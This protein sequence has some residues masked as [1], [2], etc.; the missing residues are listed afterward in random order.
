MLHK[1][2]WTKA[3]GK[4]QAAQ[5][6]ITTN[7]L[8]QSVLRSGRAISV[9][10]M[11]TLFD[12]LF[13]LGYPGSETYPHGVFGTMKNNNVSAQNLR[14]AIHP[15]KHARPFYKI[16]LKAFARAGDWLS[17]KKLVTLLHIAKQAEIAREK[18]EAWEKK[19]RPTYLVRKRRWLLRW[20]PKGEDPKTWEGLTA[21]RIRRRINYLYYKSSADRREVFYS[22]DDL[23]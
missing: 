21:T 22:T 12:R 14:Q 10:Q 9:P 20:R 2:S 11:K 1:L 16:F 4:R 3:R 8:V 7:L 17:A 15:M 13:V 19:S 23:L 6:P 18:A 5:D